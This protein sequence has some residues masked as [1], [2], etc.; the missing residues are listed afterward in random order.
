MSFYYNHDKEKCKAHW[1]YMVMKPCHVPEA[2]GTYY[3]HIR[4]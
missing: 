4:I 1:L 2:N 3:R